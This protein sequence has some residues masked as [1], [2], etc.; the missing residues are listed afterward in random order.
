MSASGLLFSLF[1][2]HLDVIL[3]G[4]KLPSWHPIGTI[5]PVGCLFEFSCLP[6]DS[7]ADLQIV[8]SPRPMHSPVH[9]V[10]PGPP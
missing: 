4:S 1:G 9:G 5:R 3:L 6:L 10:P 8:D 7:A 2:H